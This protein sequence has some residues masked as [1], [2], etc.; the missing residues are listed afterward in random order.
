LMPHMFLHSGALTSHFSFH[1]LRSSDHCPCPFGFDTPPHRCTTIIYR[2]SMT[3]I[4]AWHT[5]RHQR[6]PTAFG[7]CTTP[8]L[9]A[10]RRLSTKRRSPINGVK[11]ITVTATNRHTAPPQV[12]KRSKSSKE[13]PS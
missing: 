11:P 5:P 9:A 10:S 4:H 12:K 7:V 8:R 13:T 3:H 6:V 2:S 1:L